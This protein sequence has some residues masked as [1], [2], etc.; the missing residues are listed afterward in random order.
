V[1]RRKA[2]PSGL[3]EVVAKVYPSHEPED[4]RSIRAF[5]FW[6]RAVPERVV[7]NA[8]PVRLERGV[9]YVHAATTVWANEIDLL[10]EDFLERLRK[11][12][13]ESRIRAIRVKVGR[14]PPRP[15]VLRKEVRAIPPKPLTDLPDE[16][17]RALASISD[18][19]LR[20]T[21]GSAASYSLAMPVN[22]PRKERPDR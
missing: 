16:V 13:P 1:K 3:S 8:R 9:L 20:K 5:V 4:V 12:A 2:H 15:P 14:L 22:D 10:K 17:A 21:I 6:E 7:E 19:E 11:V 18:D